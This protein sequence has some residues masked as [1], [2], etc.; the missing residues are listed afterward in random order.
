[1]HIHPSPL[2]ITI[3]YPY[4]PPPPPPPPVFL[5]NNKSRLRKPNN[6]RGLD[7]CYLISSH[8]TELNAPS[9]L[10]PCSIAHPSQLDNLFNRHF[11]WICATTYPRLWAQKPLTDFFLVSLPSRHKEPAPHLRPLFQPVF[12][13]RLR[14]SI[15]MRPNTIGRPVSTSH[16]ISKLPLD[17]F[18]SHRTNR[19]DG[20]GTQSD[21]PL[22]C[23]P[24]A[25]IAGGDPRR[26]EIRL[27][28]WSRH[29]SSP[30]LLPCRLSPAPVH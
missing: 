12:T 7:S 11:P 4:F 8:W 29:V 26:P 14:H 28:P 21:W 27:D 5:S 10:S 9:R 13:H 24:V 20:S 6:E 22:I 25:P 17:L 16:L 23:F 15:N 30:S 2:A 19:S 1:M 3:F 18:S